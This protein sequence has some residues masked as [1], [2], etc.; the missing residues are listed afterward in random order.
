[1]RCVFAISIAKRCSEANDFVIV[2]SRYYDRF[3]FIT[4]TDYEYVTDD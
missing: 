3:Y 2:K 1:M 4:I